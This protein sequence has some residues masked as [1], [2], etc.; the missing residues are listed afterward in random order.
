MRS[1]WDE[2]SIAAN[3]APIADAATSGR[4]MQYVALAVGALFLF[5]LFKG[6]K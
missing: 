3:S 1:L 5:T 4:G 2:I 6:A